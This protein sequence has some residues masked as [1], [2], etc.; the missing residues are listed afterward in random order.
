M[1]LFWWTVS[2]SSC[3]EK[4]HSGCPLELSANSEC[5]LYQSNCKGR[6]NH[7]CGRQNCYN[8][9]ITVEMSWPAVLYTLWIPALIPLHTSVNTCFC[10]VFLFLLFIT[11]FLSNLFIFFYISI[12]FS[13][14]LDLSFRAATK[15]HDDSSIE[16]SVRL[17]ASQSK[18]QTHQWA[19]SKRI[20]EVFLSCCFSAFS[21]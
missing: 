11:F 5:C 10:V 18:T 19:F 12:F 2:C 15:G 3:S 20:A 8:T 7:D 4:E 14:S 17:C 9:R 6:E 21:P 1:Q 13:I 16:W